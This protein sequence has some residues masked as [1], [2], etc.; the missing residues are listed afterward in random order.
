MNDDWMGL[1]GYDQCLIPISAKNGKQN[2][3]IWNLS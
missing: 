2:L 1:M 3:R